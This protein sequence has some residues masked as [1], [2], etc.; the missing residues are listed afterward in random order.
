M[1][2]LYAA[3]V[4]YIVRAFFFFCQNVLVLCSLLSLVNARAQLLSLQ[5]TD[6]LPAAPT[7]LI[8]QTALRV[9][10]SHGLGRRVPQYAACTL[11]SPPGA[12]KAMPCWMLSQQET[13]TVCREVFERAG[14]SP[15]KKVGHMENGGALKGLWGRGVN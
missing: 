12:R 15:T 10:C 8:T 11:G 6:C 2:S 14:G 3:S 7:D 13:L 4:L 1:H 9:Q 5:V